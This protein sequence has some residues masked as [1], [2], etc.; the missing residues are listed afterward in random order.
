MY[1]SSTLSAGTSNYHQLSREPSRR[2]HE[3][4]EEKEKRGKEKK[5][6]ITALYTVANKHTQESALIY[7]SCL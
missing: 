2:D 6:S 1:T 3:E 7:R 5:G 4:R